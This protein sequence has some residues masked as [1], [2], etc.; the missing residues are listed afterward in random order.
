MG[1][2]QISRKDFQSA[3]FDN[4]TG[5]HNFASGCVGAF[6]YNFEALYLNLVLFFPISLR[7]IKEPLAQKALAD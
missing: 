6:L 3:F 2:L 7:Y 5:L 4:N 1:N